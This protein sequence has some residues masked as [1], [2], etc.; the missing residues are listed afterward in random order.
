MAWGGLRSA[1]DCCLLEILVVL[2]VQLAHHILM[3]AR[4]WLSQYA[5]R[6]CDY[7]I[8]RLIGQV[9]AIPGRVKLTEQEGGVRVY[10]RRDH[11]RARDVCQGFLPWLPPRQTLVALG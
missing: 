2:L 1:N 10:L 7:G 8:V 5:P 11:P 9:W 3:W 6:L 4:F